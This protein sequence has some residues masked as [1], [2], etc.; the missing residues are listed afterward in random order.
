MIVVKVAYV[1]KSVLI[2]LIIPLLENLVKKAICFAKG[3]RKPGEPVSDSNVD[4]AMR[5]AIQQFVEK[6]TG[7]PISFWNNGSVQCVDVVRAF[8]R[9]VLQRPQPEALGKDGSAE[10]FYTRHDS[11]PV[12]REHFDRVSFKRGKIPPPGAIIAFGPSPSNR[13]GH[14]GVCLEADDNTICLFDQ[15]GIAN[16]AALR[17]GRPQTGAGQSSWDYDRVLGWLQ[18]RDSA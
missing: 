15:D 4:T 5:N 6:F 9:D 7:V 11:R 3:L 2:S 10:W 17:A 12:Q 16:S 14:I 1:L 8:I 18:V 13:H